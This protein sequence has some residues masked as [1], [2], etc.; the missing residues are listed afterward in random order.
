MKRYEEIVNEISAIVQ[1]QIRPDSILKPQLDHQLLQIQGLLGRLGI[2][3]PRGK[4]SIN[5]IGSAWK[6]LA[7]N[8]DATDWDKIFTN[9][10]KI[11]EN[12]N[13]QYKINNK[14]TETVNKLIADYNTI[15]KHLE[16]NN[17]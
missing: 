3:T 1:H 4:R 7:G 9:E 10:N 6:W 12:S 16:H 13:E 14:L 8:P 5:W 2:H 11:I 15:A 17:T